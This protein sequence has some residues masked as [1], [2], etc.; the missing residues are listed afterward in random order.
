MVYH[1]VVP[2]YRE[3]VRPGGLRRHHAR[4][5]GLPQAVRPRPALPV[6]QWHFHYQ[7]NNAICQMDYPL[8]KKHSRLSRKVIGSNQTVFMFEWKET[9][10]GLFLLLFPIKNCFTL[11]HSPANF[12]RYCC[13]FLTR[14]CNSKKI[15]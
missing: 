13:D 9:S 14:G 3:G 10:Q 12:H 4:G 6:E 11:N 2:Q 8:K 15:N 5:P 1:F 7:V